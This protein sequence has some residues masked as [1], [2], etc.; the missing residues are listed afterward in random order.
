MKILV[1]GATGF[2]GSYLTRELIERNYSVRCLVRKTSNVSRLPE[3]VELWYG[4]LIEPKMLEHLAMGIDIVI[5]LAAIGDI[6]AVSEKHYREYR[7]V[8]V[9]GTRNL[10]EECKKYKNEIKKFIHFSSLAAVEY[11]SLP[12]GRSKYESELVVKKSGIPYVIL[13]P[14]MVYDWQNPDK[15][16]KKLVRFIKFGIVPV[17]GNGKKKIATIEVN[18]LVNTTLLIINKHFKSNTYILSDKKLYSLNEIISVLS[19]SL[20][21][22]PFVV[23]IP[24][25]LVKI[26]VRIMELLARIFGFVPLFISKRIERMTTSWE[27]LPY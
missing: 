17:I 8:N 2:I 22:S 11:R 16:L 14:P 12:Y 3:K 6:N 24:V 23:Y 5:H 19:K 27:T 20:N 13:R 26:P 7:K 4:D 9:E 15:E 1:T 25:V 18:D 21:K 10:L